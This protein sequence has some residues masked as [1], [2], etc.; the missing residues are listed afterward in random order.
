MQGLQIQAGA[1]VFKQDFIVA[2]LCLH[3]SAP[4]QRRSASKQ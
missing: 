1:V 4:E 2:S 3:P